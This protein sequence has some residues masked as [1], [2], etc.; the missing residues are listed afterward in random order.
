MVFYM[1]IEPAEERDR[2]LQIAKNY[3]LAAFQRSARGAVSRRRGPERLFCYT[4]RPASGLE[5]SRD[6][7]KCREK[8]FLFCRFGKDYIRKRFGIRFDLHQSLSISVQRGGAGRRGGDRCREH[9]RRPLSRRAD[10]RA[11]HEARPR[12]E[13]ID[14]LDG[15]RL[16]A[17]DILRVRGTHRLPKVPIPL[18]IQP[19]FGSRAEQF[20]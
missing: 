10:L 3:F 5:H 6:H 12:L 4:Y 8:R 20:R 15:D 1:E 7:G 17:L 13:G 18:T 16:D 9:Q 2:S 11:A 19:E 14:S